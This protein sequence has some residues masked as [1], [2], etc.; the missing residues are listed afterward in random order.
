MLEAP[1][2]YRYRSRDGGRVNSYSSKHG[3]REE[4]RRGS[5]RD[6]RS[7]RD[8]SRNG[9]RP[10][11]READGKLAVGAEGVATDKSLTSAA[12]ATE[13]PKQRSAL[14]AGPAGGAYIPPFR[15]LQVSGM[16]HIDQHAHTVYCDSIGIGCGACCCMQAVKLHPSCV[17]CHSAACAFEEIPAYLV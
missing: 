17:V 5:G 15:L 14:K 2:L 6:N 9:D 10:R 1:D 11:S 4:E 12:I 16:T 7:A 3:S 13:A 8:S